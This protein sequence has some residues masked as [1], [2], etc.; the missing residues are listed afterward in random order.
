MSGRPP[1]I[2]FR[3]YGEDHERLRAYAEAR[4]M[5][6][7]AAAQELVKAQLKREKR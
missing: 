7:G 2:R 3:L 4:G 1:P 6:L 5:T